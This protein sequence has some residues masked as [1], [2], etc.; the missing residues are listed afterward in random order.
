MPIFTKELPGD[1]SAYGIRRNHGPRHLCG[2]MV[3]SQYATG[4]E[5]DNG[6]SLTL[7]T[8]AEGAG[9]PVLRHSQAHVGLFM[10]DGALDL[11]IGDAAIRLEKGDYASIPQGTAY[12]YRMNRFRN[13]LLT[14]QTGGESGALFPTLGKPYAGYV[15]PETATESVADIIARGTITGCDTEILAAFPQ[16]FT[17]TAASLRELPADNVAFVLR[18]GEGER[19]VVADQMFTYL[20]KNAHSQGQFFT[21]MCEGPAGDM[22]PPHYHEKHT[23]CFFCLEGSMTMRAGDHSFDIGPGDFVHVTPGTIHAYQ[24]NSSYT[25]MVGF[26][27]PGVFENFFSI[28]GD[29]Y[30]AKVYPQTP[31]PF[32]FGRVLARLD[33]LDMVPIGKPGS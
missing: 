27:T 19:Y 32:E 18:A 23:E 26:L 1:G 2:G 7:L 24:L 17:A 8:G 16:D 5:T 11:M 12:G 28:L 31:R 29:T 20:S 15:Q 30:D 13:V 6:F 25:Q 3:A 22:I 4:A 10:V 9:L 14:F 33:E 21:L